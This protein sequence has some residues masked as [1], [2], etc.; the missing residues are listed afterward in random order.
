MGKIT[1]L[2]GVSCEDKEANFSE[3]MAQSQIL[4]D[5]GF[6]TYTVRL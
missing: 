4:W 3:I 5:N 6:A 1:E 2:F